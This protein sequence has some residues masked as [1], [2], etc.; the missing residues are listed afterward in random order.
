MTHHIIRRSLAATTIIGGLAG[1]GITAAGGASAAPPSTAPAPSAPPAPAAPP[2]V[3]T[4][5]TLPYTFAAGTGGSLVPTLGVSSFKGNVY[6]SNSADNLLS[7]LVGGNTTTVAGSLEAIG[8]SGDGGPA[9]AATFTQPSG[10]AEDAAGNIYIAD[11]EDNVIRKIDVG[12]GII[13]RIAG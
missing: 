3:G 12:S 1:V 10:T 2:P 9:T 11:T 5:S 7:L 13:T 8:E 6:V 4:L